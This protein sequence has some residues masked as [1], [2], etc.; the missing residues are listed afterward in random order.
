MEELNRYKR[1][2]IHPSVDDFPILLEAKGNEN[3]NDQI[4][5]LIFSHIDGAIKFII[6]AGLTRIRLSIVSKKLNMP[7]IIE[8]FV[9][10]AEEAMTLLYRL[11]DDTYIRK[12][13]HQIDLEIDEV[14]CIYSAISGRPYKH[15][16][17]E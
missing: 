3:I 9:C 11:E 7:T 10:Y 16:P 15:A 5:T 13:S 6:D 17:F 14:W 12:C 4:E 8:S 1:P 2:Y